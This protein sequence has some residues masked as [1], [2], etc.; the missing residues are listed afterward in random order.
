[1]IDITGE[2]TWIT[3]EYFWVNITPDRMDEL[4]ANRLNSGKASESD[5]EFLESFLK[6]IG[7]D[8]NNYVIVGKLK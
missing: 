2:R 8:D 1:M 5:R 3:G 4:I 7:P 6:T